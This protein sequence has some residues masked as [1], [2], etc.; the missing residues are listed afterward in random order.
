VGIGADDGRWPAVTGS[1]ASG[2]VRSSEFGLGVPVSARFGVGRAG[3][4]I[5]VGAASA[6]VNRPV[7][8]ESVSSGL[9]A[10]NGSAGPDADSS[11]GLESTG[12]EVTESVA[13]A[14]AG[15][16]SGPPSVGFDG[17]AEPFPPEPA[18]AGAA[19]PFEPCSAVAGRASA[20]APEAAGGSPALG[21]G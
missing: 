18:G 7:E 9:G 17:A 21:W 3:L 1:A 5:D 11:R 19:A 6:V 20:A 12:V 15:S 13:S 8:P 10:P 4:D 16:A 2:D 14:R